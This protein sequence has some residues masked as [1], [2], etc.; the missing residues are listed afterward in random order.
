MLLDSIHVLHKS[1][2]HP[3]LSHITTPMEHPMVYSVLIY[4][5]SILLPPINQSESFRENNVC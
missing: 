1:G 5:P 2:E 4:E 3:E